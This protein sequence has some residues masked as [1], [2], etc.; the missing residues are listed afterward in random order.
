[1]GRRVVRKPKPEQLCG[2]DLQVRI[3]LERANLILLEVI[4]A[5]SP[6]IGIDVSKEHLDIAI[7]DHPKVQ[8][9]PNDAAGISALTTQFQSLQPTLIVVESTGGYEASL[10]AELFAAGL[11]IARVNPGRV[12]E[13]AKSVGQLAKTDRIDA[14]ILVRFAQAVRPSLVQL[15]SVEAQAFAALVARRRQLIEM[16]IAEQNRLGTAPLSVQP[17]IQK[18]LGWLQEELDALNQDIQEELD[19]DAHWQSQSDLLRSVPGIGPITVITL[20]AELPELG[21]LNRKQIAALVGIAPLNRDSGRK[22]GKRRTQG[23]RSQVRSVLYMATLTATRFNPVIKSFYQRLLAT[24]K[25]KKV[26]LVACMRKLLTILNA[27]LKQHR[28]WCLALSAS[29]A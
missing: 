15:P 13:F 27:M 12:R 2:L 24:G 21:H 29:R 26:A 1:M 19:R 4:M 28:P 17:R 22:H 16:L 25:V 20:I 10:V 9:V 18:H 6:F 23:G 11:P 3:L 14:Q 5:E 7:S 8:T